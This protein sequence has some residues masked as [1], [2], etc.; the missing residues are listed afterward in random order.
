MWHLFHLI[1]VGDT[2]KATTLRRVKQETSTGTVSSD[3]MR[4]T[5]M[6]RII[7]V[8][9]DPQ[10]TSLRLSGRNV[11]ENE[12]VKMGQY[13]TLDV[14]PNR[15]IT[16]YKDEWDML[17]LERLK[18][19]TD[20]TV[21]ADL[22][23]VIMQEGLAHVCL[24]TRSM[25][26]LRA[27]VETTIPRKRKGAQ[28]SRDK[29]LLT[30]NENVLQAIL[31]HVNFEV[32]KC[33]VVASPGFVKDEFLEYLFAEAVRR[34]LRPLLENR[35]KFLGCH[36]S[37]GHKHSLKEV[38]LDPGV[39]NRMA[40]TKAAGEV[41]ILQR[42]FELLGSDPDRTSYGPRHVQRA[43]ENQ[44]I[45]VLMVTDQLIRA[46]DVATRHK[47]VRLVESV[48]ESGGD[49]YIFSTMHVSGEQLAR[50][51]GI[52]ALLRFPLPELE[53]EEEEDEEEEGRPIPTVSASP[54]SSPRKREP[55]PF[56]NPPPPPSPPDMVSWACGNPNC[57]NWKAK[58]R[59]KNSDGVIRCYS[60]YR[61]YRTHGTERAR[62]VIFFRTTPL[63]CYNCR[64]TSTASNWHKGPGGFRLCDACWTYYRDNGTVRPAR[65]YKDGS[66]RKGSPGPSPC[67][68]CSDLMTSKKR[69]KDKEWNC[70]ACAAYWRKF[71]RPRPRYL[72]SSRDESKGF[73]SPPPPSPPPATA[74][75]V[76]G[77]PHCQDGTAR[78]YCT[79]RD[80]VTR[81]IE[82]YDYYMKNGS[83]RPREDV[84]FANGPRECCRCG[85]KRS[86]FWRRG[87]GAG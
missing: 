82:C 20:P 39:Q 11:E 19:A 75:W 2:V 57:R 56:G 29:A 54:P 71:G 16:L 27:R 1:V 32:V 4:V 10:A 35:G 87:P 40:D 7:K 78:Q 77:N 43:N 80:S 70:K 37:T 86:Q 53:E 18:E 36:A 64:V 23:A 9:F 66:P 48:K 30:F 60:C 83:D 65:F 52:A 41:R 15:N 24:I 51:S 63:E 85:M 76:C 62:D 13:H 45:Q 21:T 31:R 84:F 68:V 67:P 25:T 46:H 22:A 47:Y 28:S 72:W 34:N 58:R 44:A 42:F 33:V 81:C 73:G 3:R 14:E 55:L 74:R 17:F 8:D 61:H 6:L 5:L 49:V 12:F 50:L 26:I 38:L 59:R 79:G 69:G